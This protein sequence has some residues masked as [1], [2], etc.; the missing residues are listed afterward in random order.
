MDRFSW[1]IIDMQAAGWIVVACLVFVGIAI[2]ATASSSWGVLWVQVAIAVP[3][4][5]GWLLW[6]IREDLLVDRN[7]PREMSAVVA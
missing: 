3:A 1:G 4:V 6:H 5:V 2:V 7:P